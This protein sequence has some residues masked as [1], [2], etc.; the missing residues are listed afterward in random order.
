MRVKK[1]LEISWGHRVRGQPTGS[2]DIDSDEETQ[3]SLVVMQEK[4][5][6]RELK[7]R[8][9]SSA[10]ALENGRFILVKEGE[11]WLGGDKGQPDV[12][13]GAGSLVH[14]TC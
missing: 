12:I 5:Q 14:T 2:D 10:D 11:D 6:A 8:A 9:K 3:M 7:R 4:E 13:Y 1:G